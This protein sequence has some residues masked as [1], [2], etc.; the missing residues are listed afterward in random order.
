MTH[1]QTA[2][3]ASTQHRHCRRPRAWTVWRAST[4][5][6]RAT[7]RS[8]TAWRALQVPTHAS[9]SRSVN[10]CRSMNPSR[11]PCH[12]SVSFSHTCVRLSSIPA[13][14][15][16]ADTCIPP[17]M[18]T[19]LLTTPACILCVCLRISILLIPVSPLMIICYATTLLTT[20]PTCNFLCTPCR[21]LFGADLMEQAL[22]PVRTK[23][24]PL[25]CGGSLAQRR[26][27]L[28]TLWC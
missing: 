25:P 6:P 5:R 23:L 17:A 15:H 9:H 3:R 22:W 1:A 20:T 11:W 19:S 24:M 28:L 16:L 8:P 10:T 14:F 4:W 26:R 7:T 2:S 12:S 21:S 18:S 27:C 13:R